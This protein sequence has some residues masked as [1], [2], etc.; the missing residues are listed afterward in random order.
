MS[1][2][3]GLMGRRFGRLLVVQQAESID[4]R[5][6]WSCVCDCG[7]TKTILDKSL[8][9]GKTQS[10]G[11]L[12]ADV[13]AERNHSHGMVG[14]KEY[15][16]W[17]HI[18][19]RCHNPN[20]AAYANYGGRG[21]EL[22]PAWRE[23]FSAFYAAIGPAPSR[24]LTVERID[25]DRGYEPGNVKWATRREQTRNTR[26]N[27]RVS[28]AGQDM[29]L[30]DACALLNKPYKRVQYLIAGRGMAPEHALAAA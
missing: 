16:A 11:C 17:K 24:S 23:D 14:S 1:H 19:G 25:N 12:Q 28:V 27:I 13:T 2:I 30:T 8:R 5:G 7:A 10:C 21:I 9:S 22:F 26:R 18:K 6:A 29:A 4:G 15:R 3:V 20:D